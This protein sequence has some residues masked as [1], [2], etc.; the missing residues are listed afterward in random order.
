MSIQAAQAF[1]QHVNAST[2]LQEEV[3]R[4][5]VD[6]TVDFA[7]VAGLGR[8]HGFEFTPEDAQA[9]V[10]AN[11]SELSEFELELVSG[12]LHGYGGNK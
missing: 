7:G 1:R 2:V 8:R 6:G 11:D 9:V 5:V 4:H 10:S 12:G 3:A